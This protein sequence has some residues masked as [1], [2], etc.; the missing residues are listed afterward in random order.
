MCL[1][2]PEL[3]GFSAIILVPSLSSIKVISYT[4]GRVKDLFYHS[5]LFDCYTALLPIALHSAPHIPLLLPEIFGREN[6]V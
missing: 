5:W 3:R 6:V 4:L 1:L 2:L